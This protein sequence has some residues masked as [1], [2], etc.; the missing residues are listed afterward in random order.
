MQGNDAQ[1]S[2]TTTGGWKAQHAYVMALAC[3]L[4]GVALGY[5]LRGSESPASTAGMT[6]VTQ[7]QQAMA[8]QPD[9]GQMPSLERMKKMAD[10]A[11]APLLDKLKQNPNDFETLN[12]L[13]K[14]YRGTHQFKEAVSYYE[15][16][17][18]VDPKNAAVRTDL[19]SCL[20]YEGNVDGALAQLD[21]ALESDPQF[22][23]ALLNSGIIKMRA[24][25]D[26]NGAIASWQKILKSNADPKQKEAAKR[27]IANARQK[28]DGPKS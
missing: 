12:E 18:T 6:P 10:T 7:Q 3:L 14:L 16:A 15:R 9:G 8:A 23:G 20:Y 26:T 21:R 13:G 5:L 2:E 25:N 1:L 27:L 19:A 24:K 11:A 22:F 17:L 4:I 28:S